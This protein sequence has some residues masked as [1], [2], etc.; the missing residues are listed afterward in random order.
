MAIYTP[1]EPTAEFDRYNFTRIV[2]P[3]AGLF[4]IASSQ[5]ISPEII[6]GSSPSW[7]PGGSGARWV[8]TNTLPIGFAFKFNGKVYE[9]FVASSSGWIVLRE[10]TDTGAFSVNDYLS[11]SPSFEAS[12]SNHSILSSFTTQGVLLCP[13][14]DNL[15]LSY[16]NVE[17]AYDI[18]PENENKIKNGVNLPP[19]SFDEI[20]G[21]L[22]YKTTVDKSG[23]NCLVVRW[24]ARASS[25]AQI[26]PG[27]I[28]YASIIKFEVIIYENGKIE[29]RYDSRD[30]IS[31]SQNPTSDLR[32]E[33]A[34]VGIFINDDP[35]VGWKFRDFSPGLGHPSDPVRKMSKYGGAVYDFN[36]LDTCRIFSTNYT[37]PYVN[38]LQAADTTPGTDVESFLKGRVANWPGQERF[39][40]IFSFTPP[41]K[42]RKVLP[43]KELQKR[44]ARITL[45]S[46]LRTGTGYPTQSRLFDDRRSLVYGTNTIVDYP[47][48]LPRSFTFDNNDTFVRDRINLYADFDV[49]GSVNKGCA[50]PFLQNSTVYVSPFT[51]HSRPEQC[52]ASQTDSY[53]LTGSVVDKFGLGFSSRLKSKTQIKLE[54]PINHELKMFDVT[55][56]IYYY[57]A[58]VKGFFIPQIANANNDLANSTYAATT[59]LSFNDD[60]GFGP[61]GNTVSSGTIFTPWSPIN[62]NRLLTDFYPKS[63]Q[64][65]PDYVSEDDELLTVPINQPFLLEKAVI[66][67][68]FK[69]GEGWFNDRT[70]SGLPIG[71][72]PFGSGNYG[73]NL[74][75]DFAGPAIT[76]ALFNQIK[77]QQV[78]RDLILTGTII[79]AGDNTRQVVIRKTAATA[80]SGSPPLENDMWL[81][82]PE[83]FL[84]FNSTPSAVVTPN[85]QN[86]Y[87]GSIVLKTTPGVSNGPLVN[88]FIRATP[89]G[90]SFGKPLFP[91]NYSEIF[92]DLLT[93]ERI[94][95]KRG[96]ENIKNVLIR[97]AIVD[98]DPFGRS[99]KGFNPSG[100]SYFG[101]EFVTDQTLGD[102]VYNPLFVSS[103][104]DDFPAA[105]KNVLDIGVNPG[106]Q[107]LSSFV[108][109]LAVSEESPYLLFPGDKLTLSVSKK[110]PMAATNGLHPSDSSTEVD[111]WRANSL[112]DVCIMTGS[113]KITLY[114]SLVKE[115]KEFHDTLN[116]PLASDAIHEMLGADPIGD[117]FECEYSNVLFGSYTDDY[118][119]GSL[120][121]KGEKTIITGTRGRVF[122]RL[123]ARN[124]PTPDTSAHELA[125]NPYKSFRL[126][127]WFERVGDQKNV[128]LISQTE[129]FYDSLM[130]DIQEVLQADGDN[131]AWLE[132]AADMFSS[133]SMVDANEKYGI[134]FFDMPESLA[135]VGLSAS[136][137]NNTW[138]SSFPFES[139]FSSIKRMKSLNQQIVTTKSTKDIF[140]MTHT[141]AAANPT[142]TKPLFGRYK[143]ISD[144]AGAVDLVCD[145]NLSTGK[146]GSA[147][148]DDATKFIFGFGDKNERQIF[149]PTIFGDNSQP[150]FRDADTYLKGGVRRSFSFGPVI[151]GW[152]YGVYSG[153]PA[154]SK[155][156]FR[157]SKY[158]QFRDML[159]QRLDA[160]FF[161][162]EVTDE[163]YS[164]GTLEAPVLVKF[165]DAD[166][167]LTKPE[168]T[169]SQNL[170]FEVTSSLPYFDGET[171]SRDI[172]DV[173]LNQYKVELF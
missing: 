50:D 26:I 20:D 130:P 93:S 160:K 37:S 38:S 59:N 23:G 29:F 94:S 32:L 53:Y 112:H 135:A 152:K 25:I 165:V 99:G 172:I 28:S 173:A 88:Y 134:M 12:H 140:L 118:V 153:L 146:T 52:P 161:Q 114:G 80:S 102:L 76:V 108:V 33:G 70:T 150:F 95:F 115:D 103:S 27:F 11:G 159:E 141:V 45:P 166:G 64:N 82:D 60:R 66:E 30:S 113:V 163:A 123:F 42:R 24:K 13:W 149:G 110:R 169:W 164:V 162:D 136:I 7:S 14:F 117:Q 155:A 104:Y 167:M 43:K 126:Q 68:P 85:P 168:K 48:T 86:Q 87:T 133:P 90:T 84:C 119:T 143:A 81:F 96:T 54:L 105:F 31:K 67:I 75:F 71:W 154:H 142:R 8:W 22:K 129:R 5:M 34:T 58:G 63:V 36:F 109:P 125:Q 74:N 35:N 17:D 98:V 124:Q 116:Q 44:D 15:G 10:K 69:M 101:K 47:T 4:P 145:V 120:A 132:D 56:S 79:P 21:G 137:V 72:N 107:A 51:D 49:T 62:S 77:G 73:V 57:N 46:V 19:N 127:P 144:S 171:R 121:A 40:A 128:Q 91:Q 97:Q 61:I 16:L 3:D 55:S 147:V 9:N 106:F 65:N 83:G 158:G 2:G 138:S 156:I 89:A 122:S 139:R 148:P 1:P 170:S 6:G 111:I 92:K 18:S 78:N 41:E 157:R 131:F 39:G 151:R 100:R